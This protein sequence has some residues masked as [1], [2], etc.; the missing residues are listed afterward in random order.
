MTSAIGYIDAYYSSFSQNFSLAEPFWLRKI[1][2]DL[3]ILFYV[4][5]V[6]QEVKYSKSKMYI[7]ELILDRLINASSVHNN[8]VYKNKN[9]NK[10][11]IININVIIIEFLTSQLLLGNI[12]LS[13]DIVINRIRIGGLIYSLKSF[14]QLNMCQ[15]LQ[16]FAVVCLYWGGG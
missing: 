1:T 14:L 5:I 11:I 2:T 9:N 12:H 13:W 6:S 15:E 16:I 7:S 4:H 8:A 3:H 10:L